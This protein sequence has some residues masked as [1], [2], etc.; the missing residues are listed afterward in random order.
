MKVSIARG[1]TGELVSV[2]VFAADRRTAYPTFSTDCSNILRATAFRPLRTNGLFE[3]NRIVRFDFSN[4][5][6]RDIKNEIR[7][8]YF[9][10]R[11][12]EKTVQ[13]FSRSV[14]TFFADRFAMKKGITYEHRNRKG[15]QN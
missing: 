11:M 15:N 7:K 10:L 2:E 12:S 6:K 3:S 14:L 5:G 8:I 1:K 9:T 4:G 13:V